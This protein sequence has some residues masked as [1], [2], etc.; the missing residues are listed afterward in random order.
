MKRFG[1]S[2]QN[3][4][5]SKEKKRLKERKSCVA[6]TIDKPASV[7]NLIKPFKAVIFTK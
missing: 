2:Q 3:I 5:I 1:V 6:V 4:K 7:S